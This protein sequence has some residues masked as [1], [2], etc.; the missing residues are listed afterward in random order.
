M[1]RYLGIVLS[2]LLFSAV[3]WA[4]PSQLNHELLTEQTKILALL[5]SPTIT[6]NDQA[7]ATY[8]IVENQ[9][10]DLTPQLYKLLDQHAMRGHVDIAS[11]VIC[12][13]ALDGLIRQGALPPEALLARTYHYFPI[14]TTIL[15]LNAAKQR[16]QV[17]ESMLKIMQEH[18]YDNCWFAVAN[19]LAQHKDPRFVT[20][21]AQRITITINIYVIDKNQHVGTG[22]S[23]HCYNTKTKVGYQ[24]LLPLPPMRTY[25]LIS[26]PLA[27]AALISPGLYPIYSRCEELSPEKSYNLE[28]WVERPY[29]EQATYELDYLVAM[30]GDNPIIYQSLAALLVDKTNSKDRTY[31]LQY[32]NDFEY[33]QKLKEIRTPIVQPYQQL[34]KRLLDSHLLDPEQVPDMAEKVHFKLHDL[35]EQNDRPLPS[36]AW[37]EIDE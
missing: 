28:E 9:L 22:Q 13:I 37:L 33:K 27:E 3:T 34:I 16:G 2:I 10:T 26:K 5:Q 15:V 7:W 23:S 20:N 35:R 12:H 31:E 18:G 19:F 6:V 36:L 24:P 32:Q 11:N 14:E 17:S 4:Q 1:M 25:Q 30:L 8:A 29:D 21:L